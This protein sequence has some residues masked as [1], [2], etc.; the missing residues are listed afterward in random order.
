VTELDL[1]NRRCYVEQSSVNYYTDAIVKRDIK[2][3]HENDRFSAL[4]SDLLSCDILVRSQVA[5][6]KKIRFK[7]HENV[8]YG[9]ISL[10]E[11]EMHT[12]SLV[13]L[14]SP[15]SESGE[16]LAEIPDE[17]KAGSLVRLGLL[18]KNVAPVFLLCDRRDIGISERLKDPHFGASALYFYDNYPGGSGLSDAFIHKFSNIVSAALDLLRQCPCKEG[19]PSCVGAFDAKEEIIKENPKRVMLQ[20]MEKWVAD[21]R[22]L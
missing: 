8:G 4:G 19:C 13:L 2:V 15:H 17:M 7:S 14:F 18:L 16:A 3:L 10:P 9:E 5:K 20:F 12:R 22:E 21:G 6:F 11:E 1:E